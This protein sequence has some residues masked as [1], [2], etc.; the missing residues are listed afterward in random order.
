MDENCKRM[1]PTLIVISGPPGAGKTTLAHLLAE[2]IPC[3]AISRDQ[4]K[5][6][7]CTP[8]QTSSRLKVTIS[9]AGRFLCSSMCSAFCS[10]Q[11][12]P[13]AESA[14]DDQLGDQI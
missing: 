12:S 7:W 5:G 2:A 3:P 4:I 9:P 6:A 11:E 10:D 8:L 14:F 1:R 13:V